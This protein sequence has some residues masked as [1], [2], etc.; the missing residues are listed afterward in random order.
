[1]I[2]FSVE[3]L[4]FTH[5]ETDYAIHNINFELKQNEICCIIGP[6][7]AGK[8]SL[9]KVIA[10]LLKADSG[11]VMINNRDVTKLVA[12]ERKIGF[13]SQNP[14]LLPHLNILNNILLPIEEKN[15]AKFQEK[16]LNYLEL[17]KL[18]KYQYK[19]PNQLSIGQQQK[20]SIIRSFIASPDLIL[21]DEPYANLDFLNK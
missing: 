15:K 18:T 10:G 19:Y 14:S 20:I 17:L 5:T 2:K 12:N 3:N 13:V 7:G 11:K 9:F 16:A 8:S 21:F 4:T 1:M 6:S